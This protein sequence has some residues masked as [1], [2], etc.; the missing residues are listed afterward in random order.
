MRLAL[1]L[2]S[3][4]IVDQVVVWSGDATWQNPP[5]RIVVGLP[6]NSPVAAGWFYNKDSGAFRP[7][8][9]TTGSV[10]R[11]EKID[12]MR[13]FTV[14]ERV[15]YNALRRQVAGM[16]VADYEDAAKQSLVAA[17]VM[18]QQFDLAAQIELDHPE[19]IQG[20]ELMGLL[21]IFGTEN[22]DDR[23]ASIRAAVRPGETAS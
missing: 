12:F 7:T 1:I 21:G 6:D 8:E 20:L 10:R 14:E 22:P 16:T 2:E 23:I 17:E 13:L 11:I 4:Y 15:R 3:S 9:P 19:T 18:L 5:G